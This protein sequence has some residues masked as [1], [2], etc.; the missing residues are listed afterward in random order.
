M[1]W[2][3]IILLIL[4]GL[5]WLP[6][7]VIYLRHF[8]EIAV[9]DVKHLPEEKQNQVKVIMAEQRLVRKLKSLFGFLGQYF[10]PI[11]SLLKTILSNWRDKLV[12]LEK[13]YKIEALTLKSVTQ[14][15][16]ES[17]QQKIILLLKSAG[18]AAGRAEYELAEEQFI[19]VVQLDPKS[20]EAFEGLAEIYFEQ[21]KYDQ[22]KEVQHYLLKIMRE[23]DTENIHLSGLK[24]DIINGDK[25][26]L[27]ESTQAKIN[28]Q[29]AEVYEAE[30]NY[31]QAFKYYEKAL[32]IEE[33]NP[34]YLDALLNISIIK[35][36]KIKAQEL[37]FK[38][39]QVNPENKKL[40]ELEEKIAEL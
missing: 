7:V 30:E 3:E 19:Q 18:E 23:S 37:L 20:I 35:K 22:A 40:A 34:K 17:L 11:K 8:P 26:Q 6:I 16:Q 31:D 36:D 1:T 29:L 27:L 9:I 33:N 25:K 38:L 28:H 10:K 21:K 12:E 24:N 15:G 32:K 13:K 5:L 14:S 39:N 2:Y 4:A